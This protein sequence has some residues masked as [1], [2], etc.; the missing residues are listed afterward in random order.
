[1][2]VYVLIEED[3]GMGLTVL[4]VYASEEAASAAS[5]HNCT[6]SGP[7]H[8]IGTDTARLARIKVEAIAIAEALGER[9]L[10]DFADDVRMLTKL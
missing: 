4:N 1:M 8:I 2:Q 7:H 10:V 3:R 6:V 9:G 5:R